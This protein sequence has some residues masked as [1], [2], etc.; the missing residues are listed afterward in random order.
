MRTD[1][2]INKMF[3]R[4][5]LSSKTYTRTC[6]DTQARTHTLIHAHAHTPK[7]NLGPKEK[8][9]LGNVI[10]STNQRPSREAQPVPQDTRTAH[11]LTALGLG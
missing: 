7:T 10:S 1:L 4:L 5:G 2:G 3:I 6:E 8:L 9:T 11:H